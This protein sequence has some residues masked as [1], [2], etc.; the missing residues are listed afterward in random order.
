[1]FYI[2]RSH[3]TIMKPLSITILF[4][5][6]T[7][8]AF[9][10]SLSDSAFTNKADA[11]NSIGS[12][13]NRNLKT[14]VGISSRESTSQW[15]LDYHLESIPV[16]SA[17]IILFEDGDTIAA[18]NIG[19]GQSSGKINIDN[20]KLHTEKYIY[21]VYIDK[22]FKKTGALQIYDSYNASEHRKWKTK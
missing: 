5:S 18:F 6:F 11:K 10:Q 4:F 8:T 13:K 22:Q 14:Y 17:K 21:E 15:I 2:C 12:N 20:N 16:I 7:L 1:M 9:G 3:Y 19:Y